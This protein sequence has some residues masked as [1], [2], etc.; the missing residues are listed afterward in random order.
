MSNR[1]LLLRK[2]LV[3]ANSMLYDQTVLSGAIVL[4]N[5]VYSFI[6][7]VQRHNGMLPRHSATL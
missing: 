4:P 1:M 7:W 6:E 5:K 3:Y 2:S